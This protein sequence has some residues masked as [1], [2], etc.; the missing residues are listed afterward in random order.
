MSGFKNMVLNTS[1]ANRKALKVKQNIEDGKLGFI[2]NL[3]EKN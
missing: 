2:I 3:D 1:S